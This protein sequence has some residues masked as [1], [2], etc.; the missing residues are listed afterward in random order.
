MYSNDD[1]PDNV[2][3]GN[4][5]DYAH[6]TAEGGEANPWINIVLPTT[7]RVK[8]IVL[9]NRRSS[10]CGSRTFTGLDCTADV[11]P[12]NVYNGTNQG[13]WRKGKE[14]G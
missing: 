12:G 9:Y 8:R 5:N 7:V 6:T 14:H 11:V 10:S 4:I 3:N 2:I 1:Q 13:P